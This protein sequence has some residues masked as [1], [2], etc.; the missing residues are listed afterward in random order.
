M[1][2]TIENAVYVLPYKGE[3]V[4]QSLCATIDLEGGNSFQLGSKWD[5]S[6]LLNN[7]RITGVE[8]LNMNGVLHFEVASI[9]HG[10]GMAVL[11]GRAE[12]YGE[13][14]F[15]H[16]DTDAG[17]VRGEVGRVTESAFLGNKEFLTLA[18]YKA[19]EEHFDK[20]DDAFLLPY[21]WLAQTEDRDLTPEEINQKI[22][23]KSHMNRIHRAIF[24]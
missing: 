8:V 6:K 18:E 19:M 22:F 2:A 17:N 5:L 9:V 12:Y 10:D 16:A 3:A 20:P 23:L 13:L 21:L 4:D 24:G 11:R 1:L 7:Y 15:I 14:E